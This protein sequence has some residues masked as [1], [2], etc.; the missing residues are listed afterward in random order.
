MRGSNGEDGHGGNGAHSSS[1]QSHINHNHSSSE[2][3]VSADD[4]RQKL[5]S[6]KRRGG[7]PRVSRRA[8]SASQRQTLPPG[9]VD[10]K[11]IQAAAQAEQPSTPGPGDK[12]GS[13]YRKKGGPRERS[14]LGG[15]SGGG[16]SGGGGSGDG[17][18]DGGGGNDEKWGQTR[19]LRLNQRQRQ[20]MLGD[21]RP[22]RPMGKEV[23]R[24]Q[25]GSVSAPAGHLSVSADDPLHQQQRRG[26]EQQQ[27]QQPPPQ[28]RDYSADRAIRGRGSTGTTTT[29]SSGG[30]SIN[31]GGSSNGGSSNSSGDGSSTRSSSRTGARDES[32]PGSEQPTAADEATTR[33]YLTREECTPVANP[34]AELRRVL[35]HLCSDQ[36]DECFD[37]LT[38]VRRLALHH[39][40][41][42]NMQLHTVMLGMMEATLNLRSSVAKNALLALNDVVVG[43][44]HYLDPELDNVI[45]KLLKKASESSSGFIG[46]EADRCLM[47][48][49]TSCTQARVL[50]TL[51]SASSSRVP[52][53]RA[54]AACHIGYCVSKL[55][56]EVCSL[57]ELNRLVNVGVKFMGEPVQDARHAGRRL[58]YSL[59]THGA[60]EL[61]QLQ[62]LLQEREYRQLL[63]LVQ[64]GGPAPSD[65]VDFLIT[66]S[67]KRGRQTPSARRSRSRSRSLSRQGSTASEE[68]ASG[69]GGG[70]GGSNTRGGG[71]KSRQ[72]GDSSSASSSSGNFGGAVSNTGS[73]SSSSSSAEPYTLPPQFEVLPKLYQQMSSSD[74][75]QRQESLR[76]TVNLIVKNSRALTRTQDVLTVFDHLTP[77]LTDNNSKVNLCA[78]RAMHELIPAVRSHLSGVLPSFVSALASNLASTNKQI[79]AAASEAFNI[80]MANVEPTTA[81][82]PVIQIAASSKARVKAALFDRVTDMLPSVA[83]QKP[84]LCARYALPT[85]LRAMDGSNGDLR[86]ATHRLLKQLY[87]CMGDDMIR[88]VRTAQVSSAIKESV[89]SM[90]AR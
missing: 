26:R 22:I 11:M 55:G 52:V 12:S 50:S 20:R 89:L 36:W 7:G 14:H 21:E 46:A 73:S 34:S 85:A 83:V 63:E 68:N 78:V 9:M 56:N 58:L 37:A 24:E 75:R 62:R 1:Q 29:S 64:S 53:V 42:L 66:N 84:S 39:S 18:S 47:A 54:K 2:V 69:G 79:H 49:C 71:R 61:R 90:V 30:G 8:A 45:P 72:N 13:R 31:G 43:M 25:G 44:G 27:K 59:Y 80:L 10:T 23:E 41:T 65:N 67:S 51:M 16:G 57:R 82:Q 48:M 74:W 70:G 17:G 35:H 28:K 77:R 76:I 86:L 19:P 6:L 33:T 15:G 4:I 60:V 3:S 32:N 40:A 38:S 5:S 87:R 81:F 88:G